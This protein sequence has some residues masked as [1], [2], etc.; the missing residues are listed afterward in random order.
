MKMRFMKIR[1]LKEPEFT[2][3]EYLLRWKILLGVFIS[4]FCVIIF[5]KLIIWGIDFKR[6]AFLISILPKF[7]LGVSASIGAEWI[8]FLVYRGF[9]SSRN[10]IT[11]LMHCLIINAILSGGILFF[12]AIYG[13]FSTI[14][15]VQIFL[16]LMGI[17]I[18]F[19]LSYFMIPCYILSEKCAFWET[20]FLWYKI[21]S[22]PYNREMQKT[23]RIAFSILLPILLCMVFILKILKI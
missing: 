7:F 6:N 15:I 18:G 19:L 16:A 2:L 11:I 22:N 1:K 12:I 5:Y 17:G 13:D 4:F 3:Y 21:S 8:I 10:L 14:G 9:N 23:M 20:F